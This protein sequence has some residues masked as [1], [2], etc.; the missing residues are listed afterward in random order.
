LTKVP[1][2]AVANDAILTVAYVSRIAAGHYEKIGKRAPRFILNNRRDDLTGVLLCVGNRYLQILEGPA[3]NV[4]SCMA[5]IAVD[6]AHTDV[7]LL[8]LD[9]SI[10]RLFP[11]WSMG[12]VRCGLEAD[13][14]LP[15]LIELHLKNEGDLRQPAILQFIYKLTDLVRE[16]LSG[17]D[18]FAHKIE[19]M[20]KTQ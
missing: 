7:T 3:S 13:N 10:E 12:L 4:L 5:R 15:R 9:R 18:G 19:L 14:A 11:E 1:P 6:S 2:S 17:R 20:P 16:R 8:Y